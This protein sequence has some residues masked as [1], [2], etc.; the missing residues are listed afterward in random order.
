MPRAKPRGDGK[1]A[2]PEFARKPFANRTPAAEALRAPTMAD[3]GQSDR[4]HI[5]SHGKERRPHRRSSP[6]R[7]RVIGVRSGEQTH[8]E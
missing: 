8:A 1:A 5:A 4:A 6:K 2:F 3:H 7:L